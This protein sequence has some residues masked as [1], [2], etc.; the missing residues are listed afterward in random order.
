M[1]S[2]NV[3]GLKS[4]NMIGFILNI[5]WS[6]IGLLGGLVSAPKSI[7]WHTKP[8]AVVMEVKSLWWATGYM[9]GARAMAIGHVVI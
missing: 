9:K 3:M 4:R 5:P 2:K 1:S 8:Y 6:I 7:R